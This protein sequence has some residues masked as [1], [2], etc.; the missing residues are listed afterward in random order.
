M[1]A[2]SEHSDLIANRD[3]EDLESSGQTDPP[4]SANLASE[5]DSSQPEEGGGERAVELDPGRLREALLRAHA[6][7]DNQQKRAERELGK[8]RR[9]GVEAL[10]RDLLPVLDSLEQGLQ[11]SGADPGADQ[12]LALTHR[13]LVKAM[14]AHGLVTIEAEDAPFDPDWHEAI[15]SRVDEAHEP[16]QVVEVL[17]TGYRLHERLLR[18]A[19]VVVA[20]AP[21][22]PPEAD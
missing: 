17:Q 13:L 10:M 2:S 21:A 8:A 7:L 6:D 22:D 9:F 4:E 20:Q 3:R 12:G 14:A 18:P 1:S 19:R 5:D 15:A 16:G 11:V